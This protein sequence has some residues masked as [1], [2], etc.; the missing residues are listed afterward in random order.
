MYLVHV[1]ALSC[2]QSFQAVTLNLLYKPFPL[3]YPSHF[4]SCNG[5]M[6]TLAWFRQIIVRRILISL[7]ANYVLMMLN[8]LIFRRHIRMSPTSPHQSHSPPEKCV[9][10]RCARMLTFWRLYKRESPILHFRATTARFSSCHK[11][12]KLSATSCSPADNVFDTSFGVGAVNCNHR[13]DTPCVATTCIRA[14][15]TTSAAAEIRESCESG[16]L[17][18]VWM[19]TRQVAA[20]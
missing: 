14:Y 8:P 7:S 18:I 12:M 1:M 10:F 13:L 9:S 16:T 17:A 2:R 15:C 5:K 19:H 3:Y 6:L 20:L 4:L 11:P